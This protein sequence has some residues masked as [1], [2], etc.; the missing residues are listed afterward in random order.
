MIGGSWKPRFALLLAAFLPG[1]QGREVGSCLADGLLHGRAPGVGGHTGKAGS[2]VPIGEGMG[3]LFGRDGTLLQPTAQGVCRD[4][5]LA[6]L[7]ML[8]RVVGDPLGE[9]LVVGEQEV[10][11]EGAG[12]AEVCFRAS[13]FWVLVPPPAR[14]ERSM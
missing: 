8:L 9:L 3:M 4:R 5:P 1:R 11:E 7:L 10:E 2:E 14:A 6:H 13:R 12:L